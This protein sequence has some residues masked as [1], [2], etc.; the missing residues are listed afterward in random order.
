ML[1][2]PITYTNYDGVTVT[3]DFYFHFSKAEL[4]EMQASS[5]DGLAAQ[6]DEVANSN[7]PKLIIA[8]FKKLILDAYGV[9]SEDGRRFEKSAGLRAE[10]VETEAFS[11]LFM[12]L[13]TDADAAARFVNGVVPQNLEQDLNSLNRGSGNSP[14]GAPK[15]DEK[16]MTKQDA[17]KMSAEELAAKLSTGWVIAS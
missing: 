1:K 12:L 16:V 6:L 5:P 2:M 8:T 4:I 13:C 15:S 3:E 11:E 10:F 9:K 14:V 17:I 7:D